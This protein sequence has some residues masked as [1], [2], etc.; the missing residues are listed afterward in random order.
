MLLVLSGKRSMPMRTGRPT[1]P[2]VLTNEERMTLGQ[3]TRR[4]KTGQALVLRARMVLGCGAGKTSTTVAQELGVCKPTVGKWRRRFLEHCL[5]GLLDEPRPGAPLRVSDTDVERVL[6]LTL[7]TTPQD[8]THWSPRSMAAQSGL[9]R[10]TVHRVWRAFGLQPHRTEPSNSPVTPCSLRKYVSWGFISA[11]RIV[12]WC[13]AWMRRPR[14]RHWTV[15][16]RCYLCA[17]AEWNGAVTTMSA[18]ARQPCLLPS[19]LKRGR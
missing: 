14:S 4:S 15:P 12:P 17:P 3:W 10:C 9:S 8:A 1:P 13:C 19:K 7:E 2:L 6:T 18:T 11:R 5:D 16:A